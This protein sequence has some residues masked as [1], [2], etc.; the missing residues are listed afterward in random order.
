MIWDLFPWDAYVYKT[1]P[2]REFLVRQAC[3]NAL[4]HCAPR[5]GSISAHA[6]IHLEWLLRGP[7]SGFARTVRDEFRKIVDRYEA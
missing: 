4:Q 2:S 5:S 7:E 1:M 3:L 6:A